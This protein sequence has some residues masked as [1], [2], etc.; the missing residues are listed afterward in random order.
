[1]MMYRVFT[2]SDL[3]EYYSV[4]KFALAFARTKNEAI[5]LGR[6]L[7]DG[8]VNAVK[9]SKAEWLQEENLSDMPHIV[10][11]PKTCS[12]CERWGYSPI[13]KDG[14]CDDCRRELQAGNI[15]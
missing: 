12:V 8:N 5:E 4:P 2:V 15:G 6:S 10:R 9:L 11:H 3:E 13:G 7:F 14:M 1:M